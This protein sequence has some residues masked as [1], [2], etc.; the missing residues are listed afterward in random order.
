MTNASRAYSR[1][2]GQTASRERLM[3]L[4][5]ETALKNVRAGAA[6]LEAKRPADANAALAKAA[7]IVTELLATLDHTRAPEL[8]R[9]LSEIYVFVSGRLLAALTARDPGAAREAE[10]ALAPVVDGFVEAVRAVERGAAGA[11]R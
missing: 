10:R 3:V 7:D 11:G 1:T 2:Q 4:L 6:A 9:Q 8:C 5:L